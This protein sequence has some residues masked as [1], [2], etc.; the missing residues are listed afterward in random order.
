MQMNAVLHALRL[1]GFCLALAYFASFPLVGWRFLLPGRFTFGVV[2]SVG[3]AVLGTRAVAT[4]QSAPVR[5]LVT[6]LLV[7][8]VL[9]L[10]MGMA[11]DAGVLD[12]KDYFIVGLPVSAVIAVAAAISLWRQRS[13]GGVTWLVVV[14]IG[15]LWL[16]LL[17]VYF[18]VQF[19]SDRVELLRFVRIQWL[20]LPIVA[21]VGVTF[22]AILSSALASALAKNW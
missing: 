1:A 15:G 20:M 7:Y 19:S 13:Q 9:A 8:V 12:A 21:G 5:A 16:V 18:A 14:K 10:S 11:L 22:S 2:C 17:A 3:L 6:Y 4:M